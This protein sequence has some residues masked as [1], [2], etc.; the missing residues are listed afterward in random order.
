MYRVIF[1]K[2]SELHVYDA[3]KNPL[4]VSEEYVGNAL[5]SSEHFESKPKILE[6][7]Y[8]LDALIEEF[9]NGDKNP[10]DIGLV[11]VWE[12]GSDYVG[13]YHITSLLDPD[14]LWQRQYHGVSHVMTNQT[15]GQRE[16]DLIVIKEL[17]EHLNDPE[18][19]TKAQREKYEGEY[20]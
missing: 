1:N 7:K 2:P 17:I 8:S 10:K 18:N 4:G 16:M 14:N 20:A 3:E 11:V 15:S 5:E 12:T 9:G 6:Y 13:S 19:S